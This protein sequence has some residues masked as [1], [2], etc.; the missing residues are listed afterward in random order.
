VPRNKVIL[1]DA[2][3][4][5]NL[6]ATGRIEEVLGA[7]DCSFGI[8]AEVAAETLYLKNPSAGTKDLVDIQPLVDD[9]ILFITSVE[10]AAEQSSFV[11]YAA[12]LDDGEA[13]S[14]AIATERNWLL[15]T[16]DRKTQNL[17]EREHLRVGPVT[18]VKLLQRWQSRR[19]I[20]DE[21]M[22]KVLNRIWERA[23][24]R[25]KPSTDEGQWWATWGRE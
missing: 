21:S 4:L 14:L 5:L 13:M 9:G 15:A 23:S 12:L 17:I 2:C 19:A 8:V 24:Y 6:L 11:H 16:D 3:V 20:D 18:T 1:N 7:F 22:S 25:P 10:T